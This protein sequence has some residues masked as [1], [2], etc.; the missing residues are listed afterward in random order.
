ME[1]PKL[2]LMR[3][4]WLIVVLLALM[5][6]PALNQWQDQFQTSA[7]E[8]ELG[9]PFQFSDDYRAKWANALL[10]SAMR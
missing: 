2:R 5:L 6:S 10:A 3:W 8:P 1:K 9:E 7:G 4:A